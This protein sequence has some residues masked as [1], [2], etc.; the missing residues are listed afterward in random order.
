[1]GT[2]LLSLTMAASHA[3]ASLIA[4]EPFNYD[5]MQWY[6]STTVTGDGIAGLNGGT[7]WAAPWYST[8]IYNAGVPVWP[9]DYPANAR[10]APLSYT[11]GMGLSLQTSGNQM[12]TAY[13][14]NSWDRRLLAEPIGELGS[15]VWVSFLAQ[16]DAITTATSRYAFVELANTGVNN[17][18]WIGKVTPV[19]TGNWGINLPD[20][21]AP[22]GPT[23]ADFGDAAKMNQQTM[24]LMKLDFPTAAD[25]VTGIS[26]WLN[27]P[28]LT[29]ESALLAPVFQSVVN[30]TTWNQVGVAGR[31]S[32]DF[33][34]IRIGTTFASVTPIPE[35]A[36]AF[37]LAFGVCGLLVRRTLRQPR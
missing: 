3:S 32:T 28:D 4:Y 9:G 2:V 5:R 15:T 29:D 1:M 13:G 12:R 6:A 35:P 23:S 24:F 20:N 26:V 21:T 31:Y 22:G 10:T 18:L 37:L 33:D 7:G 11:D 36:T 8:G 30:Y 19:L 16:S 17:R 27:P 25:G 14:N 34:E